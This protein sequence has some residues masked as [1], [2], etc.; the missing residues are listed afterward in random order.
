MNS[1]KKEFNL[2]EAIKRMNKYAKNN[3]MKKLTKEEIEKHSEIES[4]LMA[5]KSKNSK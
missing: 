4:G 3:P 1:N 2:E 5:G